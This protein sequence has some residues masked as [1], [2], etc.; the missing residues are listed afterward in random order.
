MENK[1]ENRTGFVSCMEFLNEAYNTWNG[2]EK[3][4]KL[5]LPSV[6]YNEVQNQY[7]KFEKNRWFSHLAWDA[8]PNP[9]SRR[10]NRK[11]MAVNIK[12][13]RQRLLKS[14]KKIT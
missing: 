14:I 12:L 13:L 7:W 6:L 8:S 5:K 4:S 3:K 11:N 10:K 1:E 9:Q 2:K